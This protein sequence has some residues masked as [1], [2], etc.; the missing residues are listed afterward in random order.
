[1]KRKSL[2]RQ[3]R[4]LGSSGA[5]QGSGDADLP[6]RAPHEKK[7]HYDGGAGNDQDEKHKNF[8]GFDDEEDGFDDDV[9]GNELYESIRSKGD[10]KKASKAT[11]RAAAE[12]NIRDAELSKV[13]TDDAAPEGKKRGASKASV[14]CLS[15]AAA[16]RLGWLQKIMKNQ[17]LIK[18]RNKDMK[19]PRVANKIKA[20]RK[21]TL[22][23]S[24]AARTD[25]CVHR[26]QN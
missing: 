11:K 16:H 22:S 25:S 17:G 20:A 13:G 21:V 9:V 1:M 6:Y 3:L 2:K 5:A 19:N 26:V 12:A 4:E 24:T 18:Y 23:T 8:G 15:H 7:H 10:S 14:A